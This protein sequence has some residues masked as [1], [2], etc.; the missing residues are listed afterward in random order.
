MEFSQSF[1]CD[2]GLCVIEIDDLFDICESASEV[3][4]VVMV[5]VVF[6]EGEI[7]DYELSVVCG[8]CL[9]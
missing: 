4:D 2:D 9:G 6:A 3:D 7:V 1:S 8:E 5:C